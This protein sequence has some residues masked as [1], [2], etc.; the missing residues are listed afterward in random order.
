MALRLKAFQSD[1][2]A[3]PEW[4]GER[5]GMQRAERG[6]VL[7]LGKK[8]LSEFR[9]LSSCVRMHTIPF[10]LM[11]GGRGGLGSGNLAGC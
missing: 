6:G 3:L 5:Q 4:G 9:G 11:V 1:D 7:L 10:Y 8:I 2:N